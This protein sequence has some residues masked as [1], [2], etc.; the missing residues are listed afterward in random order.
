MQA[1]VNDAMYL[2]DLSSLSTLTVPLHA[3]ATWVAGEWLDEID[4]NVCVSEIF[5]RAR[6]N[7]PPH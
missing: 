2:H 4:L 5:F 6:S 3:P 1:V 7:A